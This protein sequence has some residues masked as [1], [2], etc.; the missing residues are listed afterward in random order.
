MLALDGR[1]IK[2]LSNGATFTFVPDSDI[3]FKCKRRCGYEG[4]WKVEQLKWETS[5]SRG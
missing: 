3:A 4:E 2:I 5:I 1:G